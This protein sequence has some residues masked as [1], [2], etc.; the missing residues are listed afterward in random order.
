GGVGGVGGSGAITETAE[1]LAP[2]SEQ[3]AGRLDL[4]A[5]IDPRLLIDPP[6]V[7]LGTLTPP[8]TSGPVP[9]PAGSDIRSRTV[10]FTL[11]DARLAPEGS[12]EW[13][14]AH[15]PGTGPAVVPVAFPDGQT[16]TVGEGGT[17]TLRVGLDPTGLAPGEYDGRIVFTRGDRSVHATY[18]LR[19]APAV[20]DILLINV[21]RRA[22]AAGGGIPGIP[23]LPGGGGGFDDGPDNSRY[24]TSALDTLGLTHDVWTVAGDAHVGAPPLSVLDGYRLVIVA[25]GDGNAPL[26][27]L[28]GGM[29]S[30]QMYLLGGGRMLISGTGYNHGLTAALDT[31]TSG[32]MMLLSR[33]FAGFDLT[34]D[35]AALKSNLTPVR[36]FDKPIRLSAV[37]SPDAGPGGA[38]VDLGVPLASLRTQAAGGTQQT[39]PDTG[40]GAVG[41]AD[42]IFPY[43]HSFL[44]ID[45]GGTAMTGV[46][47]DATLEQPTRSEGIPWRAMFAGFNVEAVATGDDTL[48]RGQV[49]A[50]VWAWA[51][52]ADDISIHVTTAPVPDH[53]ESVEV[54]AEALQPDRVPIAKRWRWDAGDGRPPITTGAPTITLPYT[55]PGRYT[56]RAEMTSPDAHTY[57]GEAMAVV[58][59]GRTTV[60]LPALRR[61]WP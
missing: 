37:A 53:P 33:Y 9:M 56:I 52:E 7:D 45:G 13:T 38:V 59:G 29:T 44:E 42:R 16:V 40:L 15:A 31:Q 17:A 24:W 51:T 19:V 35:N 22:S 58:T 32:A 54:H 4:A 8:D 30:L 57:V 21:R 12:A 20:E 25:A 43:V 61:V 47:A 49:L 18:R 23:G 5:A 46:T 48:T 1:A 6:S 27:R 10:R 39:P 36:L 28:P 50:R 55:R 2:A 26:D 60:Y 3:G 34:T 41:V 11:T 14:V